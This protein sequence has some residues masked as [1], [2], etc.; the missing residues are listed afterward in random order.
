MRLS[1]IFNPPTGDSLVFLL[2]VSAYTL[3]IIGG[4]PQDPV[5]NG[6]AAA[7][8]LVKER[9]QVLEA[10]DQTPLRQNRRTG[11]TPGRRPPRVVALHR[12]CHGDPSFG[13]ARMDRMAGVVSGRLQV[14]R[15]QMP[16]IYSPARSGN[17]A[18]RPLMK[19]AHRSATKVRIA[20]ESTSSGNTESRSK[21]EGFILDSS[22]LLASLFDEPCLAIT[23]AALAQ[24][25][26]SAVNDSE[27]VARQVRMGE[28]PGA[29][30][31][32]ADSEDSGPAISPLL[33]N[34]NAAAA[35]RSVRSKQTDGWPSRSPRTSPSGTGGRNGRQVFTGKPP[36]LMRTQSV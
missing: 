26:I 12:A 30:T 25:A 18:G 11:S 35:R 3:S 1:A 33:P 5:P 29:A 6:L 16:C 9:G 7:Y 10:I 2:N 36:R 15:L 23:D 32:H 14:T 22:A 17:R 34:T 8:V 13:F 19:F 27:A 20:P 31:Y 4:K 24:G 28:N 21:P